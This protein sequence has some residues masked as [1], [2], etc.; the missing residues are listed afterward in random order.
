MNLSD[1]AAVAHTVR[2]AFPSTVNDARSSPSVKKAAPSRC[3]IVS[4]RM[5]QNVSMLLLPQRC[6]DHQPR[7]LSDRGSTQRWPHPPGAS[8][9]VISVLR[10]KSVT[11]GDFSNRCRW[12]GVM[13]L[14]TL[15]SSSAALQTA[16]YSSTASR[17]DDRRRSRRHVSA[18]ATS[19]PL[20]DL[21][22]LLS[23]EVGAIRVCDRFIRCRDAANFPQKPPSE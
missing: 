17:C 23:V 5:F 22:Q 18:F 6:A 7:H 20:N 21:D 2:Q 19:S 3:H 9:P 14:A 10:S 15:T 1:R 8:S 12:D 11:K 4:R 13:N 16:A